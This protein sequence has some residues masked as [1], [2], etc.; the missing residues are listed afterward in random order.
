MAESTPTAEERATNVRVCSIRNHRNV[1]DDLRHYWWECREGRADQI[2]AAEA[3]ARRAALAE[4]N[5]THIITH[6]NHEACCNEVRRAAFAEAVSAVKLEL[7]QC[8]AAWQAIRAIERRME[9][10]N[11][12]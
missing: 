1:R 4:C 8:N 6:E 7:G 12:D 5:E 3:S 2:R 9:K 11:A 10:G